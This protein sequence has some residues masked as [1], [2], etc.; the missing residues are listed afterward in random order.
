MAGL[1]IDPPCSV[2]IDNF[3]V[4]RTDCIG[5]PFE[6]DP[7]LLIDANG[8]LPSSVT[9]KRFQAIARQRRQVG[10]RRGSIQYV[11]ALPALTSGPEQHDRAQL[12]RVRLLDAL[13]QHR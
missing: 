3:D 12:L 5:R 4:R 13:L 8:V 9:S 11:E 10:K 1:V 2:I 7:P 6:T